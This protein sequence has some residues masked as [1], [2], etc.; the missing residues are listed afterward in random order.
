MSGLGFELGLS[1]IPSARQVLEPELLGGSMD[2][3]FPIFEGKFISNEDGIQDQYYWFMHYAK[4][5]MKKYWSIIDWIYC[6]VF[7]EFQPDCFA[8]Y[9]GRNS[10]LR[11]YMSQELIDKIDIFL[12]SVLFH[13]IKLIRPHMTKFLKIMEQR[14]IVNQLRVDTGLNALETTITH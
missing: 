3:I 10:Q 8:Y 2:S 1:A 5:H 4:R 12:S 11:K 6:Q 9:E 7:P 14:F 13:Q